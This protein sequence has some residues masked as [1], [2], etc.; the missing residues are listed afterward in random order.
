SDN[1][2][3]EF[4]P[5][6]GLVYHTDK[7]TTLKTS[8][9]KGFK[10][11]SLYELYTTYD[12]GSLRINANPDLQP[13]KTLSYD[14]GIEHR[15]AERLLGKLMLY[16]S[17]ARNYIG[18]Y[19]ITPINWRTDNIAKVRM[20]GIETELNWQISSEWSGLI[21]CTNNKSQIIE[22]TTDPSVEDNYLAYTPRNV[23]KLGISY[24]KPEILEF[25]TVV[26]YNGKYYGDNQNTSEFDPYYTVNLNLAHQFGKNSRLSVG[27]ENLL[28]KEYTVYKGTSQDIL[29]PGRVVNLML[30]INF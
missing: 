10:A 17:N 9:A 18:Y 22:Y 26:N 5:K 15:F 12:R 6:L 25:Q 23:Y 13:E 7:N 28:D 2:W 4:S 8:V 29:A 27:I 20:E 14:L 24:N 30:N 21:N 3:R 1:K 16:Q 11:P 19:T